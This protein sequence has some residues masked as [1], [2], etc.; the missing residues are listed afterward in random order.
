MSTTSTASRASSGLGT[1][2]PRSRPPDVVASTRAACTRRSRA[3]AAPRPSVPRTRPFVVMCLRSRHQVTSAK[4]TTGLDSGA[5][6]RPPTHRSTQPGVD[7]LR[8]RKRLAS[9]DRRPSRNAHH[10][11]HGAT[12]DRGV[13]AGRAQGGGDTQHGERGRGHERHP[14]R[15]THPEAQTRR[16]YYAV[17]EAWLKR[18]LPVERS[19]RSRHIALRFVPS[20][21]PAARTPE[22]EGSIP[23][24]E[25]ADRLGLAH[26]DHVVQ[27]IRQGDIDG[28][29]VGG[30]WWVR[31]D[32]ID[33]YTTEDARSVSHQRAAGTVGQHRNDPPRRERSPTRR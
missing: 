9:L 32:S 13:V 5:G 17:P 15:L 8:D 10:R 2:P 28:Q 22:P 26:S 33:S 19:C 16:L 18:G 24:I 30:R 1:R 20:A 29:K 23:S 3:A 12:G 14:S 7:S 27:L 31:M 25:A 11:G 21:R 6:G 4:P